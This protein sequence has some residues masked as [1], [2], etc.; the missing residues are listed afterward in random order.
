MK[1]INKLILLCFLIQGLI[2]T[3][4]SFNLNIN[5]ANYQ[6]GDEFWTIDIPA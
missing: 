1:S 5:K 4:M 2:M 3:G 6:K